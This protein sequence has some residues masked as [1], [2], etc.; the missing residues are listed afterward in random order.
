MW[1]AMVL[2]VGFFAQANPWTTTHH[3]VRGGWDMLVRYD[4][5]TGQVSCSIRTRDVILVRD[6]LIF[7]MGPDAETANAQF[8][9]DSGPVHSVR[10]VLA[11]DQARGFFP[12]RGWIEDPS[13]AEVAIPS[14]WASNAKMIWIRANPGVRPSR[15]RIG[16]LNYILRSAV[17]LGCPVRAI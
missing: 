7:R 15:F 11:L 1:I 8:R 9:V 5:F 10:E 12:D 14:A 2:A 6:T 3:Y 16:G 13:E 17:G 4:R